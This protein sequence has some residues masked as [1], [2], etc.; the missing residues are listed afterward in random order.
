ML[1]KSLIRMAVL[2]M[3]GPIIATEFLAAQN[4]LRETQPPETS[5]CVPQRDTPVQDAN[6]LLPSANTMHRS[7]DFGEAATSTKATN[8][9]EA[10]RLESRRQDPGLGQRRH[11]GQVNP[12]PDAADDCKVDRYLRQASFDDLQEPSCETVAREIVLPGESNRRLLGN[13]VMPIDQDLGE[14][15]SRIAINS[16]FVIAIA[17]GGI[18]L[19]R[20]WFFRGNKIVSLG[21]NRAAL[22]VKQI[23]KIDSRITLRLIQWRNTDILVAS[24]TTGLKS[25]SILN[26]TFQEKLDE[27]SETDLVH[28]IM[29]S[30]SEKESQ[31][32]TS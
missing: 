17:V 29:N 14:M 12:N 30:L 2:A 13:V 1:R 11:S 31:I 24:D 18:L 28:Q 9:L 15:I 27:H 10:G 20:Q 6:R 19:A 32:D 5:S 23:L 4:P 8:W 25:V 3:I 22:C 26:A 21:A 16:C 7:P